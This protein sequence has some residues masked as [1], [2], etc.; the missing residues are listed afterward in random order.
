MR[1]GLKLINHC[2]Q[3]DFGEQYTILSGKTPKLYQVNLLSSHF[4]ASKM[5]IQNA[6]F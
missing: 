6:P 1:L 4:S 5:S 2:L 3:I